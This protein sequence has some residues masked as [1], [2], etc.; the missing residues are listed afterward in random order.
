M[1]TQNLTQA[2]DWAYGH[3]YVFAIGIM[4]LSLIMAKLLDHFFAKVLKS[5]AARTKT[6]LDN[7]LINQIHRPVQISV[8]SLGALLALSALIEDDTYQNYASSG[9]FTL[10]VCLWTWVAIRAS[11]TFFNLVIQKRRGDSALVQTLPLVNNLIM[12]VLLVHGAYWVM[13]LW[14]INVTPLV[15]S[16]GIVTAAV[17]LASK[18]TL[19]NFFGGVSIFV[20]RPYKINDYIILESGERGEVVNIGIR[21]TR[22]LTRDDV[23]ITLPNAI[24]ANSKIVNQSGHINRFR[25]RIKIG[26]AYESNLDQVEEELLAACRSISEIIQNPPPRVRFRS[27]GDSALEFELLFWIRQPADKGRIEHLVNRNIHQKFAKAG[28]EIPFPQRVLTFTGQPFERKVEKS[29]EPDENKNI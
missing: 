12:I 6:D 11:R 3:A 29:A 23:L 25:L 13:H 17:A 5:I 22:I 20:D 28:I 4:V 21:S 15:A 14:E 7:Q 19:A 9:L 10:L 24:M 16:A 27:F 18:D 26:V 1:N 8:V 2:W